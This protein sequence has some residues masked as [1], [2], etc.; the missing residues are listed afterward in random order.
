MIT[1]ER[2]QAKTLAIAIPGYRMHSQMFN[3]MLAGIQEK[4]AQI[5]IDNK[6][7]HFTW[8]VGNLVNCR[9][10][11][12]GVL[13]IPEKDP[14][15][16]HFKDGKALDVAAKYPTLDELKTEWHKIS[17]ILYQKLLSVEDSEL[18]QAFEFGMDIPYVEENKL[19][20]VGMCLDRESYLFGQLG[21]LRKVLNY[22][23]VRYDTDD[24]LNY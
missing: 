17:P 20:M 4:D 2:P 13:D 6:T 18:E 16:H 8:M 19:I 24:N 15:E 3:N 10:W 21:L 11:L 7:N 1:I 12:A 5:R 22:D 9:Y 14:N 23:A